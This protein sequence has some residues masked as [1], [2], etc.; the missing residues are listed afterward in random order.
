MKRL[1]HIAA[2]SLLAV[3][4]SVAVAGVVMPSP[5]YAQAPN[6]MKNQITQGSGATGANTGATIEGGLKQVVNV[7]LFLIGA[8]SVI[9]I[10]IGGIMF[11]VSAGDAG[12]AK[13]AK[14]TILYAVIGLII[15]IL[16]FSIVNFVV[17][18]F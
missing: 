18:Q 4:G 1:I 8:V 13:K 6:T 9:V 16:A 17:R 12:R 5:A 14:D 3:F 11:T 7:L 10:I 2:I 15:A